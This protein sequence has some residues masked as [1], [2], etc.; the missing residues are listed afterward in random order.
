MG[1]NEKSPSGSGTSAETAG[2]KFLREL[3][4]TPYNN[5][6]VGQAFVMLSP[7]SKSKQN[8]V[9][10]KELNRSSIEDI[11]QTIMARSGMSREEMERMLADPF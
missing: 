3:K 5:S 8:A 6:R 7:M 4:A 11:I 2:E 9:S 10:E 1:K